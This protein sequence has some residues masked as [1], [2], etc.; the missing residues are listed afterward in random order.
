MTRVAVVVPH[1]QQAR[2]L[3]GCL[4]S[5]LAQ[6]RAP[7]EIVLVDSS[8]SDTGPIVARY[9]G[10]IRHLIRPADG[11]AAARNAGIAATTCDLISLLDADNIAPPGRLERQRRALEARPDAVLCHG[12]LIPVDRVGA[13]YTGLPRYVSEQVPF[14]RQLGWLIERNR[15]AADTVCVRRD[16]VERLGGFCEMHGVRED[17]DLWLRLAS[18]G[19]FQY[20]D[21]PLALYRRHETNLSNDEA[22]MFKWEAGA[23]RRLEWPSI[24]AALQRAFPDEIERAVVE[25]EV[26]LRR[27]EIDHAEILF[28]GLS[29][30]RPPVAAA[31]FHLAHLAIDRGLLIQAEGLL[32]QALAEDPD[33]AALWNNLGGLLV[34]SGKRDLGADAFAR[35]V[36]LRPHYQD[37]LDNFRRVHRNA[38]G[39]W[40]VTR[41]RLRPELM[42]LSAVA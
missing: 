38:A 16:A 41:R 17:Y 22:Y 21:A 37:A 10:R 36:A 27:N 30:R 9:S 5:L 40:R 4:R 28:V 39:P 23:L 42:P 33:N 8:P 24:D 31:L 32:R 26:H 34:R 6:T 14:E 3:D 35:A 7:D 19:P 1:Y 15:I 25:A 18:V 2:F 13:G 11:V 29:R 20:V 12:A